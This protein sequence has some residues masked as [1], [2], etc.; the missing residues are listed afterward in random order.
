[1]AQSSTTAAADPVNVAITRYDKS[2]QAIQSTTWALPV[3]PASLV[4]V[5]VLASGELWALVREGKTLTGPLRILRRGA[6]G[7]AAGEATVDLGTETVLG[8]RA[9]AGASLILVTTRDLWHVS[10]ADGRIIAKRALTAGA[11]PTPVE[12]A[13][14]E[15]GAWLRYRDR[16]EYVALD[17]GGSVRYPLPAY[18]IS[19]APP[20]TDD[21]PKSQGVVADAILVNRAGVCFLVENVGREYQVKG[22]W[23]PEGTT[24]LALTTI[25]PHGK[26][27][28][29]N[30]FGTVKA[31]REW[32]W[33]EYRTGRAL[34]PDMGLVRTH[35]D[36][37]ATLSGIVES[38]DG[39]VLVVSSRRVG[40]DAAAGI[41]WQQPVERYQTL[42]PIVGTQGKGG[43]LFL[44]HVPWRLELFDDQGSSIRRVSVPAN[45]G[46]IDST[47]GAALGETS[48]GD[49]IMVTYPFTFE[50]SARQ[51]RWR[52]A[53]Q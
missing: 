33:K 4:G 31:R 44:A 3:S 20:V 46:L 15:H 2:L 12:G 48:N 13:A 29:Q 21:A 34:A 41:R 35:Y 14:S 18:D 26:R 9:V 23:R 39:V 22:S 28:G 43:L 6:N 11:A 52:A 17:G 42:N 37:L 36:G 5:E 8:W 27:L 25:D 53:S 40:L 30:L 19:K 7:A 16:L 24:Q 38:G 10:P 49:W 47:Q 45:G 51:L 50:G 1:M 32:F